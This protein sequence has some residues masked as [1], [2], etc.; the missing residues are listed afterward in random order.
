M[1]IW[2]SPEANDL[3]SS[4]FAGHNIFTLHSSLYPRKKPSAPTVSGTKGQPSAVPPAFVFCDTHSWDER[5]AFRGTTRIRILR[6][7]LSSGNGGTP[8]PL[9]GAAP[10][11]TKRHSLGRLSAGGRPSLQSAN[12]LFSHSTHLHCPYLYHSFPQNA[13]R[14]V[15]FKSYCNN[16]KITIDKTALLW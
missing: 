13:S 1:E 10:G 5:P 16:R 8:V 3:K 14:K 2:N 12:P 15:C 6:Y 7:A 4:G 11:R 9:S